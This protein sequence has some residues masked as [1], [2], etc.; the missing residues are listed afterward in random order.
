[1]SVNLVLYAVENGV[2]RP[3]ISLPEDGS[4]TLAKISHKVSEAMRRAELQG[5]DHPD[6]K[7]VREERESDESGVTI[8]SAAFVEL[9]PVTLKTV[10][11]VFSRLPDLF[12]PTITPPMPENPATKK[13]R[14]LS[15]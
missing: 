2:R 15:Q 4:F 13:S 12:A 9:D 1:V 8:V 7:L 5:V 11:K 3:L 10:G 14:E 6:F